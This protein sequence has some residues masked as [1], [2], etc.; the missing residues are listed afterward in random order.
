MK[1]IVMH[2]LDDRTS[3]SVRQNLKNKGIL[4]SLYICKYDLYLQNQ[5]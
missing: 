4:P 3:S 1:C 2:E 5:I